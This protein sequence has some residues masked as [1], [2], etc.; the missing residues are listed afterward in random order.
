VAKRLAEFQAE[1]GG[2]RT[3]VT[4][5]DGT[6]FYSQDERQADRGHGSTEAFY[7]IRFHV[8]F[9]V[10]SDSDLGEIKIYNL[11]EASVK[12]FK[13]GEL[14]CLEAG[15]HPFEK[16][17]ELVIN[18]TI[19]DL[20]VEQL[21]KVTWVLTIYIGDTTDVWPVAMCSKTYSPGVKARVVA[22]D[23]ITDSLGLPIGKM[24]PKQNPVYRK[25]LSL[26]GAVRPE[27]EMVARDMKSKLHVSRRKV[28]ILHPDRGVPSGVVLSGENGLIAA[29]PAVALPQ[30][31]QYIASFASGE[32]PQVYEIS[33]LLTPKLWADNEFEIDSEDIPGMWRVVAGDHSCD[34][35]SFKTT[36]RVAKAS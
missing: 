7:L 9:D 1:G 12:K 14:V 36:L 17:K 11:D 19:E 13:R 5:A 29:K 31:M 24:D 21:T 2:W 3:K 23:L 15:Y 25:G 35:R 27:L 20:I 32:A 34:G 18:G 6:E 26:V 22:D 30:D 10:S 33:A 28:Y 16:H 8:P 4:T